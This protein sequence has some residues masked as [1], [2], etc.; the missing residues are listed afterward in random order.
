[1]AS[2]D[3]D[4]MEKAIKYNLLASN[5]IILQNMIDLTDTIHK[6]QKAGT[7]IS[8]EDIAHLS[9][10]MTSHL[11]RFADY[12]RDLDTK[13]IDVERIKNLYIFD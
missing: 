9:P 4:E 5:C 11:R 3:P 2:N 1:M 8:K 12:I 10:Y 13:P 7:S 6:L